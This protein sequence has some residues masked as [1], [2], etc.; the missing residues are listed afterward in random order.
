MAV[1][2]ACRRVGG[3]TSRPSPYW[4]KPGCR[5]RDYVTGQ[6]GDDAAVRDEDREAPRHEQGTISSRLYELGGESSFSRSLRQTGATE[7]N[8]L[9][10]L[11]KELTAVAWKAPPRRTPVSA[12]IPTLAVPE[13]GRSRGTNRALP[14]TPGSAG[15]PGEHVDR[16][17]LRAASQA[18]DW[19]SADGAPASVADAW[20]EADRRLEMRL[21]L[22]WPVPSLRMSSTSRSRPDD[23][24]SSRCPGRWVA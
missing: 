18:F 6:E 2:A 12:G 17:F 4:K 1:T 9:P 19:L 14:A 24:S 21:G 8:S 16:P 13:P 23:R 22:R 10:N 5:A 3:T 20:F 7:L 11:Q 15:C